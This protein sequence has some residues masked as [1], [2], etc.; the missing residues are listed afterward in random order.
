MM[1]Q[2]QQR[3]ISFCQGLQLAL[4]QLALGQH[5][6]SKNSISAGALLQLVLQISYVV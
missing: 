3:A 6:I 5:S 2:R 4:G 1:Q